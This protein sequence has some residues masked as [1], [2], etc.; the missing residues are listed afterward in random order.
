M[1]EGSEPS[2]NSFEFRVVELMLRV[3]LGFRVLGV[4]GRVYDA[5]CTPPTRLNI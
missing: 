2:G 1:L 3:E 5:I 4:R